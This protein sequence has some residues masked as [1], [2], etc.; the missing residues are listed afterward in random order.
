G[1][2][3]CNRCCRVVQELYLI[4]VPGGDGLAARRAEGGE[5]RSLEFSAFCLVEELDV[6]GIAAGPAAFDVMETK[7]INALGDAELVRDREIDPFTLAAVAQ[8]RVVDFHVRFHAARRWRRCRNSRWSG[9]GFLRYRRHV[10]KTTSAISA[11]ARW[12]EAGRAVRI[13]P[14]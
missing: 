11:R 2:D 9:T 7:G 8:G 14:M 10:A 3:G 1:S 12:T 5:F 4:V 6:F 13:L